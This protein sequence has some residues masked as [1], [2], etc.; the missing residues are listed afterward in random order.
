M[1]PSKENRELLAEEEGKD[2]RQ[3]QLP[4]ASFAVE[5]RRLALQ[6]DS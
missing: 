5:W 2:G 1:V 4:A 3:V 6:G